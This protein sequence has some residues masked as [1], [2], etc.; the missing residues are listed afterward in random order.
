[1]NK[2]R[3]RELIAT[4]LLGGVFLTVIFPSFANADAAFAPVPPDEKFVALVVKTMQNSALK[5]GELPEPLPAKPRRIY[6]IPITAYSSEVGQTDD[7]PFI[8]ASGT[9]VREGVV[10]ANFLRIGTKVRIPELFG[11][12]V[13]TVEDRMNP[14]Y[15]YRMDIWM[16]ETGDAWEF[17]IKHATIEVF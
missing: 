3:I 8:T 16:A 12:K 13:F 9:T 4:S 14:R 17:G 6:K 2:A 10:A 7:T 5:H 15:D 11:N 1:M